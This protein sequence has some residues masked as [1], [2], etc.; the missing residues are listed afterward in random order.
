MSFDFASWNRK[1]Q[2]DGKPFSKILA[3]GKIVYLHKIVTSKKDVNQ[4]RFNN[5]DSKTQ[6]LLSEN[7]SKQKVEYGFGYEDETK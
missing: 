3:E 7:Y 5:L 2:F 1:H 4:H 6:E